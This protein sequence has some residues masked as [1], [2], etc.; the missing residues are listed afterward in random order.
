MSE[1]LKVSLAIFIVALNALLFKTSAAQSETIKNCAGVP[2]GRNDAHV[3]IYEERWSVHMDN[4]SRTCWV[5]LVDWQGSRY[6][7]KSLINTTRDG[8]RNRY[9]APSESRKGNYD[10]PSL[11]E[12]AWKFADATIEF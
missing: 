4:N 12:E 10:R 9:G 8:L 1:I 7:C 3:I 5:Q 2:W 11:V 6:Q